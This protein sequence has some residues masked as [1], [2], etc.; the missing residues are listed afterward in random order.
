MLG[1]NQRYGSLTELRERMLVNKRL[2][3]DST[4]LI[5][6]WH[7]C[8]AEYIS[9]MRIDLNFDKLRINTEIMIKMSLHYDVT[10]R[11]T[12]VHELEGTWMIFYETKDLDKYFDEAVLMFDDENIRGTFTWARGVDKHRYVLYTQSKGVYVISEPHLPNSAEAPGIQFTSIGRNYGF[13][14]SDDALSW[15]FR[16]TLPLNDDQLDLL[17]KGRRDNETVATVTVSIKYT[18]EFTKTFGV[19]IKY[20]LHHLAAYTLKVTFK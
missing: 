11:R 3:N 8:P 18:I 12:R 16:S 1:K 9:C 19:F 6:Q 13:R 15:F 7:H 10:L 20:G 2:Y 5:E 4:V 14:Q 17:T